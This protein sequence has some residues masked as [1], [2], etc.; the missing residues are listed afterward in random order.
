MQTINREVERRLETQG[1]R[2][3]SKR[4]NTN[5]HYDAEIRAKIGRYA[6]ENGNKNAVEKFSRELQRPLSE[7]TVRG[8]KKAY[9]FELRKAKDPDNILE[10]KHGLRGKP[11][12]LGDLDQKVQKY[13]CKLH[14][15]GTPV[16]HSI[17]IAA[18][19]GVVQYHSPSLLPEHGGN[20][21]LG[22][23]WAESM[24]TRMGLVRRKATKA[25]RKKPADFESLKAHFHQRITK[26]VKDHSVPPALILNFDQTATKPV[27]TSDGC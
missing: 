5:F 7:S 12:K 18:A 25:A 15:A 20:L 26:V 3:S 10:L 13:I 17:V 8:F 1:K 6:A 11:K 19:R 23:K 27:P 22:R 16:N 21:E 24:M 4:K 2:R 14:S 9:Y